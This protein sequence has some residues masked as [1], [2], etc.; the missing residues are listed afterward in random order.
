MQGGC[1]FLADIILLRLSAAL[2]KHRERVYIVP[3]YPLNSVELCENHK[4]GGVVDYFLAKY[5]RA[6]S[7]RKFQSIRG[8]AS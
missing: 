2:K 6:G 7:I 8:L 1:R 3:D 5:P 4:Y